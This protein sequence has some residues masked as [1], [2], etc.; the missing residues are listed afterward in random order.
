[1]GALVAA[2]LL[3]H[4]DDEF[5]AFLDDFG[6]GDA[7]LDLRGLLAEVLAG[8][9]LQGEEA[10]PVGAE[11]DEGGL[12]ARLHARDARLVDVGLGLLAGAG[13]DVEVEE[14]LTVDEGD[15]QL[16]R[17]GRVDQHAFHG[18]HSCGALPPRWAQGSGR[19]PPAGRRRSGKSAGPREAPAARPA[20]GCDA[21]MALHRRPV[22]GIR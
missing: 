3:V 16:F 12:E 10:V 20:A 14:L 1:V 15:A 21:R 7:A 13:F 22:A 19:R 8:D 9:L 6:D 5:L 2:L 11:V 18:Q 4:L 17:L